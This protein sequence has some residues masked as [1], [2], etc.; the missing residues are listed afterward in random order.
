MFYTC[1]VILVAKKHAKQFLC[2]LQLFG[3][4]C[5]PKIKQI[6]NLQIYKFCSNFHRKQNLIVPIKFKRIKIIRLFLEL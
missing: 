5:P 1:E 3:C 2:F 6:N 4:F